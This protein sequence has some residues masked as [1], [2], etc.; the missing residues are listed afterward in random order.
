MDEDYETEVAE[1]A[2]IAQ[3]DLAAFSR[4]FARCEMPLRRSLGS[5]ADV[6]DVEAIVQ[7]T[8]IL[9]H[10]RAST[11]TPQRPAGFLLRWA[12]TVALNR[13]R[14]DAKRA[15]R[16]E[17]FEEYAETASSPVAPAADPFL[18]ERIRQCRERLPDKPRL[19]L[20]A[21]L[22]DGGRHQPRDLATSIGLK[23]DAFRQNLKRARGALEQCLRGY[24]INVREYLG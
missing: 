8:V 20:D 1:L 22:E 7:D 17:P 11:I 13:A 23:F 4:W 18:R 21:L 14:N 24:G 9:V 3:S 15:G 16:H 5:F 2:A 12:R 10:N 19:V 6:A